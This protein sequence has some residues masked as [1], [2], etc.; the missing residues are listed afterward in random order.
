MFPLNCIMHASP[1]HKKYTSHKFFT[2]NYRT[3][4]LCFCNYNH[5]YRPVQKEQNGILW[6]WVVFCGV[7]TMNGMKWHWLQVKRFDN[8]VWIA[9]CQ[10]GW[11]ATP[12]NAE[13]GTKWNWQKGLHKSEPNRNILTYVLHSILGSCTP[14]PSDT[15]YGIHWPCVF[16]IH[17]YYDINQ[18]HFGINHCCFESLT[19]QKMIYVGI[20]FLILLYYAIRC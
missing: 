13:F 19:N 15:K 2:F 3:I 1:S 7:V 18:H 9:L 12:S 8:V 20:E 4:F 5:S 14:L 10:T 16:L 6:R 17:V 11:K